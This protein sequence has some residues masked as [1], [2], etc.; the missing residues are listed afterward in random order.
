MD[1]MSAQSRIE[2]SKQD[3]RVKIIERSADQAVQ[4]LEHI[5]RALTAPGVKDNPNIEPMTKQIKAIMAGLSDDGV[6]RR[7]LISMLTVPNQVQG[8]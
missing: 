3:Q 8:I 4:A 5:V 7:N 2:Q 1:M 6:M